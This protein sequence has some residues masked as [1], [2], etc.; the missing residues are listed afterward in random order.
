MSSARHELARARELTDQV[1][2]EGDRAV[3]GDELAKEPWFGL[4]H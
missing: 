3:L 1:A 2:G 4:S